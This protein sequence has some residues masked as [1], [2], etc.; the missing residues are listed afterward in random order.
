MARVS[1]ISHGMAQLSPSA[2]K[3]ALA[4]QA[5]GYFDE[6][7]G[8]VPVQRNLEQKQS[9]TAGCGLQSAHRR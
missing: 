8:F 6:N 3:A 2:A 1:L 7:D 4:A 9:M 5:M